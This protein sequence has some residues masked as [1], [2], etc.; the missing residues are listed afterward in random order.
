MN[1]V[2]G[3][4]QTRTEHATGPAVIGFLASMGI[5]AMIGVVGFLSLGVDAISWVGAIVWGIVATVAFTLVT[6]MGKAMGMTRMDLLDL[7]GSMFVRPGTAASKGLGSVI[8]LM[9]GALLGIG[10]AYGSGLAGWPTNWITGLAWGLLLWVLAL[11]MMS[12]MGTVHPAIRRG[13]QDDPGFAATNFGRMTPM[14]SLVGHAVYGIVLG[15]GYQAW[16][17][18]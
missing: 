6:M 16:P 17:I 18:G 4:P 7:L 2:T 15:A 12:T 9:N 10:W 8:H 5:P 3:T 14:G 11:V 1:V 13:E